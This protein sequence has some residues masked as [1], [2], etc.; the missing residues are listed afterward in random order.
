MDSGKNHKI[1]TKL[2]SVSDML[3]SDA[4]AFSF[5]ITD[6]D[7]DK[8]T[9]GTYYNM[10]NLEKKQE[11][12]LG[13]YYFDGRMLY[14]DKNDSEY[15]AAIIA[16]GTSLMNSDEDYLIKSNKNVSN[17]SVEWRGTGIYISTTHTDEND[18]E[19]VDLSALTILNHKDTRM[20]YLNGKSIPYKTSG[21]YIYFGETPIVEDSSS[22]DGSDNT[23]EGQ[24]PDNTH[25]TGGNGNNENTGSSGNNDNTGGSN[26]GSAGGLGGNG[27]SG[28]S[29]GAGSGNSGS[30][31]SGSGSTGNTGTTENPAP[32]KEEVKLNPSFEKELQ[33][34]WGKTEI[35][36]LVKSGVVNG[37][38]DTTLG[39]SQSVTRA[40]FAAM[41]VR[42]LKIDT[43]KYD[44][45]FNDVK[46]GDWYADIIATVNRVG[47]MN[48]DTDK[49]A[50]PNSILTREQMAKMAVSALEKVKGIVADTAGELALSDADAVSPWAKE[51]VVAAVNLGIMKGVS[52][53]EFAPLNT[54]PREQAMVLVYRLMN[55]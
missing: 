18:A 46:T 26:S 31:N 34:H 49:N 23:G 43:V 12:D 16:D 33:S 13:D 5:K 48:G 30:G 1:E 9:E 52:D 15:S 7:T 42:A 11:V 28:S 19:Y 40:Q 21:S 51:Y 3:E 41:L 47:I 4:S 35:E 36:E 38:S 32:D 10:H 45:E 8:V 20:V 24:K 29:G 14:V 54:V 6:P 17:M 50:S 44:G 55:K 39:L 25:G 22:E 27:S 53:S 37:I 2:I